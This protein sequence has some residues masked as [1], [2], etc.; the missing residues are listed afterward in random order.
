MGRKSKDNLITENYVKANIKPEMAHALQVI[1]DTLGRTRTDVVREALYD[2]LR[3][4]YSE[5]FPKSE[6]ELMMQVQ[7][8][9]N[10]EKYKEE[11]RHK[12]Y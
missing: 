6:A 12:I 3:K 9:L 7:E 2:Y 1:E 5:F 8:E 4:N 10:I 11:Y